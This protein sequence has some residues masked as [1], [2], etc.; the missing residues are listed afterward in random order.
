MRNESVILVVKLST[1]CLLSFMTHQ[2]LFESILLTHIQTQ[3][4]VS[5]GEK[6]TLR[7]SG[8][9]LRVERLTETISVL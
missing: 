4:L 7:G 9:L 1:T 3:T 5:V 2:T 8:V 6:G